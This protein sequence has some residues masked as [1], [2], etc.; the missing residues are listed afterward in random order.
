MD[1][2]SVLLSQSTTRREQGGRQERPRQ[3]A[4]IVMRCRVRVFTDGNN[5][6]HQFN[7][8]AIKSQRN[9]LLLHYTNSRVGNI[10]HE[11]EIFLL[12]VFEFKITRP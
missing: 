12:V 11:S 9:V 5:D 8:T 1:V 2:H 3:H 4:S 7:Q 10:M 6:K